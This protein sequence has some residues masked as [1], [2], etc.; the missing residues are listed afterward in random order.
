ML[1]QQP[2]FLCD[3]IHLDKILPEEKVKPFLILLFSFGEYPQQIAVVKIQCPEA[4][5]L[6]VGLPV[7]GYT[8]ALAFR[9]RLRQGAHRSGLFQNPPAD[10]FQRVCLAEVPGK[11]NKAILPRWADGNILA[12]LDLVTFSVEIV[13][14]LPLGH[15]LPNDFIH[16]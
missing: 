8:I 9:G 12:N 13:K 10:A 16:I 15:G 5:Y 4:G 11:A 14:E 6:L 2:C 1:R 3:G 7:S